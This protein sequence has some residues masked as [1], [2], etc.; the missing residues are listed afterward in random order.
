MRSLLSSRV[1]RES[2]CDV[3]CLALDEVLSDL[4]YGGCALDGQDVELRERLLRAVLREKEP[5]NREIPWYPWMT[6]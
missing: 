5:E 3:S 4:G 6:R 2:K 1:R